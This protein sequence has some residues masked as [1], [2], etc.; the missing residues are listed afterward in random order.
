MTLPTARDCLRPAIPDPIYPCGAMVAR[1][2]AY[3]PGG[4]VDPCYDEVLGAGYHHAGD[5]RA[6]KGIWI[7]KRCARDRRVSEGGW[8]LLPRLDHA[9]EEARGSAP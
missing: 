1:I 6:L 7:C 3:V 9:L 5:L 2:N 4:D 8:D